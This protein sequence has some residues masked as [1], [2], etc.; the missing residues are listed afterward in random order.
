[1]L[2][3]RNTDEEI[4]KLQRRWQTTGLEQDQFNSGDNGFSLQN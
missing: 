3:R 2:Y 1:M 4:R